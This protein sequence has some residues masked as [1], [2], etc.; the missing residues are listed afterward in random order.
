MINFRFHLVSLTAVFLAL[1]MGIAMGA[2]VVDRA[3]VDTLEQQ[4]NGVERRTVRTNAA[5]QRLEG[6]VASW[7]R[8]A[9]Q[10]GDQLVDGRL[11]GLPVLLVAVEGADRRVVE[12]VRQSIVAADASL[13]ATVWLSERFLLARPE[14]VVALATALGSDA[15]RPEVL[16]RQATDR[17]ATAWSGD[18]AANPLG[19]LRDARFVEVQAPPGAPDADPATVPATGTRIVLVSSGTPAEMN[20]AVGLPLARRLGRQP[21]PRLVAVDAE[22]AA[23]TGAVAPFV[24]RLRGRPELAGALSTVDSAGDFRSRVAVVLALAELGSGRTGH[25][26]QGPGAN[27]LV[28]EPAP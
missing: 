13:Q 22:P 5:N 19:P 26:G 9:A 14:D 25:Y 15:A 28:P 24:G 23:V 10:S 18:L 27:R 8:F 7:E 11:A 2:T 20:L 3:L 16:Q 12:A 17:L 21:P 6:D 1:A 4:L